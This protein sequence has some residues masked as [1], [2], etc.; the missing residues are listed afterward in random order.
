MLD[1]TGMESRKVTVYVQSVKKAAGAEQWGEWGYTLAA[2]IRGGYRL[3]PDYK[4]HTEVTYENVLPEDQEQFVEMV[5]AAA[6]RLGFDVEVVDCA[7]RRGLRT[8][9]FPTLVTDSGDKIEGVVSEQQVESFLA[10][11][12]ASSKKQVQ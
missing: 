10:K 5:K 3:I 6:S 2:G 9:K 7:R 12:K 8:K 1:E 4:M 11:A